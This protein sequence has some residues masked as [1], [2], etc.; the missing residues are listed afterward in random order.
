MMKA[1]T[2]AVKI[3]VPVEKLVKAGEE[4]VKS[5]EEA[6]KKLEGGNWECLI[7]WTINIINLR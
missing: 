6:V 2:E 5:G 3:V 1:G 4:L 7:V